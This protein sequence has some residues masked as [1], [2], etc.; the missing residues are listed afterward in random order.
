MKKLKIAGMIILMSWASYIY[1]EDAG[2]VVGGA[3]QYDWQTCVNNK[4]GECKNACN[5]SVERDCPD[6][7]DSLA[8]DKCKTEGL[9]P[10]VTQ[11]VEPSM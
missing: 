9:S 7:C 5:Q 6:T 1:A 10:P 3:K 8:R 11:S 4:A 2:T